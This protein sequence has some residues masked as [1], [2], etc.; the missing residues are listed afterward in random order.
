MCQPFIEG[1]S[2]VCRLGPAVRDGRPAAFA[3]RPV[4]GRGGNLSR[5]MV[6]VQFGSVWGGCLV[7]GAARP[8]RCP[9]RT[10]PVTDLEGSDAATVAP[11]SSAASESR[12]GLVSSSASRRTELRL[13]SCSEGERPAPL[14]VLIPRQPAVDGRHVNDSEFL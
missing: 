4:S 14:E 6:M 3:H 12:D 10:G 5:P 8:I 1:H 2:V 11:G 9:A 7:S 13:L